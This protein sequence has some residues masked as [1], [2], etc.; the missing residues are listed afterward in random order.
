MKLSVSDPSKESSVLATGLETGDSFTLTADGSQLAYTRYHLSSNLWLSELPAAGVTSKVPPKPLTS[1]TVEQYSPSI[2]P[3][4]RWVAYVIEA[5]TKTNIYKMAIDGSQVA[6]VT[7]FDAVDVSSPAWSPDGRRIAF[8]CDKGGILKVWVVDVDGTG[9]HA[10]DKTNASDTN[11]VLAWSPSPEIVYQQ[12]G[13]HNLRRV[14]VET[15]EEAPILSKDS[16]GWLTS[17]PIFSRDGKKIAISWNQQPGDREGV[18]VISMEDH[19]ERLLYPGAY[20][21]LGWSPDGDSVYAESYD[22]GQKEIFRIP[23][24]DSK[25]TKSVITTAGALEPYQG[26]VSPD[27]H[28]IIFAL[29][30]EK[31]DVWIMQNFDPAM[32][33]EKQLP[34]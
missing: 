22:D 19:S 33:L 23:L 15:Q 16:E 6:P 17:A 8:L 14:N 34:K 13:L 25:Q 2:S 11:R 21:P 31:S 3:D 20:I 32:G 18:W 12:P 5:G 7:F 9:A 1:G 10:L 26:A 27:G 4:G 28:K 30:E 24:R 29:I